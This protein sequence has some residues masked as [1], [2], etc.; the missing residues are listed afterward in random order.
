MRLFA[1]KMWLIVALLSGFALAGCGATQDGVTAGGITEMELDEGVVEVNQTP[2]LAASATPLGENTKASPQKDQQALQAR[3]AASEAETLRLRAELVSLRKI[4]GVSNAGKSQ[5]APS[6][7]TLPDGSPIPPP[8]VLTAAQAD[9]EDKNRADA[10][11][12]AAVPVDPVQQALAGMTAPVQAGNSTGSSTGSSSEAR[13]LVSGSLS[14]MPVPTATASTVFHPAVNSA[15]TPPP[16]MA[17]R[18]LPAVTPSTE[19]AAYKQALA[20]YEKKRFAEAEALFDQF[21]QS[22]PNSTLAPNALY[23]K[24]EC[25]YSRGRFADA[26]FIFKDVLTRFP[27]HPKAPDALL[28]TIMSYR[29]LGDTD[30]A[31]LHYSVL[32]EDYP[33]STA[34]RRAKEMGL[35]G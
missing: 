17:D 23:W 16:S 4:E 25:L 30:N 14:I 26:V 6:T 8:R 5:P 10:A 22:W 2:A 9:M 28:K 20:T 18:A 21:L 33:A 29:R 31:K 1:A 3:L 35:G 13:P 24:A 12:P 7:L 27:K 34:L 32:A 15:G 19:Q 11:S